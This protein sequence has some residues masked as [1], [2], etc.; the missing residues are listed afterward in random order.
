MRP[1]ALYHHGSK[2]E[3]PNGRFWKKTVWNPC[4][5]HAGCA[6]RNI[7]ACAK[8][9]IHVKGLRQRRI[10]KI[11]FDLDFMPMLNYAYVANDSIVECCANFC[12]DNVRTIPG[13][14]LG[15]PE[16]VRIR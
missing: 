11:P 12:I 9:K 1:T 5:V 13:L 8:T 10:Y 16:K 3:I 6:P 15:Q 7:A 2:L 14:S 4:F